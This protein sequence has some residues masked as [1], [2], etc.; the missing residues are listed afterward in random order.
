MPSWT[1]SGELGCC[2]R[3]RTAA[4]VQAE[5]AGQLLAPPPACRPGISSGRVRGDRPRLDGHRQDLAGRSGAVDRAPHRGQHDLDAASRRWPGSGSSPPPCPGSAP[6][7]RRT[8]SARPR[9]ASRVMP[10]RRPGSPRRAL[11]QRGGRRRA[12]GRAGASAWWDGGR[13]VRRRS[14]APG[15]GRDAAGARD[16]GVGGRGAAVPGAAGAP[17]PARA[18]PS[19]PALAGTRWLGPVVRVPWSPTSPM[20]PG[21]G[22]AEPAGPPGAAVCLSGAWAAGRGSGPTGGVL[23]GRRG[24][25]APGRGGRSRAAAAGPGRRPRPPAGPFGPPGRSGRSARSGRRVL[26]VSRGSTRGCGP[27]KSGRRR[28]WSC[29]S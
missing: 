21:S 8:G 11:S 6:G 14:A 24:A 16:A 3:F 9:S 20:S 17:L 23:P 4:S 18:P 5:R 28:W 7:G 29:R 19:T 1:Y 15:V 13:A 26:A 22:R 25:G 12:A 2:S 27:T 10:I